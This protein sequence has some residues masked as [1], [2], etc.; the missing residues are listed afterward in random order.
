MAGTD[1]EAP[2]PTG[3][4]DLAELRAESINQDLHMD[5]QRVLR[6]LVAYWTSFFT[7]TLCFPAAEIIVDKSH[8]WRVWGIFAFVSGLHALAG[9]VSLPLLMDGLCKPEVSRWKA[10][11][12]ICRSVAPLWWCM[13]LAIGVVTMIYSLM[14]VIIARRQGP[15]LHIYETSQ[16]FHFF[17]GCLAF[18]VWFRDHRHEMC[19]RY[20]T[21]DEEL[22]VIFQGE[23]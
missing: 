2:V 19:P 22:E 13:W 9:P 21:Q 4:D 14:L 17:L 12:V 16:S 7:L 18:I 10:G 6:W 20:T 23:N 1:V 5:R 15:T 3:P 8:S 11:C